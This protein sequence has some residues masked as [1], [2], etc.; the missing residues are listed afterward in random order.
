MAALGRTGDL[1]DEAAF[2]R[3]VLTRGVVRDVRAA[4]RGDS[5]GWA[6]AAAAVAG[7]LTAGV[8][9]ALPVPRRSARQSA[10]DGA[11]AAPGLPGG[12]GVRSRSP[13]LPEPRA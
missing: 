3:T 8:A 13:E 1:S 12:G 5:S 2:A 4:V 10:S 7:T 9:F 6:R 11:A